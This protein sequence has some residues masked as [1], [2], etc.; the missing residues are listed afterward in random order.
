MADVINLNKSAA[1]EAMR[2][3]VHV[4]TSSGFACDIPRERYDNWDLVFAAQ[5]SGKGDSSATIEY[6]EIILKDVLGDAEAEKLKQHVSAN[7]RVPFTGL[8][9][10][11]NEIA[12]AASKN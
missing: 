11:C 3:M 2:D 6:V 12:E 4:E 9:R 5:K 7:G 10:E 1:A 8:L